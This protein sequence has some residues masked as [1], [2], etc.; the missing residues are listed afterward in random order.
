M[1]APAKRK[2]YWITGLP[3]SGKTTLAEALVKQLKKQG[4]PVVHLDGDLLRAVLGSRFGYCVE[5]RE[6]LAMVYSRLCKMFVSQGFDVVIATV[7]FFRKVHLWNRDNIDGYME[8]FLNA[9]PEL[10]AQRDQKRLYSRGDL[11]EKFRTKDEYVAP[12]NPHVEVIV[13][14]DL[15]IT[16]VLE[17]IFGGIDRPASER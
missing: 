4:N 14:K 7:S 2:C 8:I 1:E 12:I 11:A 6:Y 13:E 3:G 15:D 17:Q 10:L 9:T 16:L 5:D